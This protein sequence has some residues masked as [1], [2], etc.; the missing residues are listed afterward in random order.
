MLESRELTLSYGETVALAG[1][2]VRVSPSEVVAVTGPS[3]S[4]KT[5]LLYCLAGLLTPSSGTVTLDGRDITHLSPE[6]RALLRRTQFGFVFQFA[7]L[8]PEL[9]LRENVAL[10]LELQGLARRAV[11]PRVEEALSLL[12]ISEHADR[13]PRQV[14]GGQA[15]RAAVARALVHRPQVLFADEPTG[16]LDS[17]N[18]ELVFKAMLDLA[19]ESGSSVVLVTHDEHLAG[20][21]DRVI[22]MR[23]GAVTQ[24]GIRL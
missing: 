2:S 11:A 7:E 14:S 4:G 5:S 22:P 20:A 9:S 18:G 3:G 15:Q 1:A 17:T 12:G 16:A 13:R 6:E 23:D 21:A 19:R 8:V 10:P 24:V